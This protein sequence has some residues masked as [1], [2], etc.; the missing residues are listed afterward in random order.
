MVDIYYRGEKMIDDLE[1]LEPN[2][3]KI[4]Y[5]FIF[6]CLE[7]GIKIKIYNTLRTKEEQKALFLQGRSPINVVNE[8]RKKVGLRPI[9]EHENRIITLTRISPHC[10]GLAFDFVPIVDGKALWNDDNLW[11]KCGNIAEGLGLEWGGR[12]KN[13]PD[14]PHIQMKNWKMFVKM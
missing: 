5:A 1:K 14:K 3:R 8:A 9:T 2:F 4:T 10:Y 6:K 13:F 7:S 11:E 12:W